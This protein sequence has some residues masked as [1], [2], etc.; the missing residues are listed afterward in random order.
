MDQSVLVVGCA[1]VAGLAAAAAPQV[2]RRLPEPPAAE[3]DGTA[4]PGQPTDQP[5]DQPDPAETDAVPASPRRPRRP[6]PDFSLWGMHAREREK[7]PYVAMAAVPHLAL[8]CA[9]AGAVVGALVG[10]ALGWTASLAVVLPVVPVGVMIAVVD[11]RSRLIPNRLVRPAT[12]YVVAAGLVVWALTQDG[13]DLLRALVGLVVVRSLFWVAWFIRAAGMGFGDV[14]L[15]ALIGF[16]LG[17]D[18][19]GTLL[20]GVWLGFLVFVLPGVLLAVVKRNYEL[21]R[22]PV[23]FGPFMLVGAVLGLVVGQPLMV[24]VYG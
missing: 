2:I 15:S 17:Y 22:V 11:W 19:A 21:I 20:V 23:P 13:S 12:A 4:E 14:R 1:L 6:V 9:V 3:P 16:V 8:G 5:T 18:G 10:W 24:A 7:E